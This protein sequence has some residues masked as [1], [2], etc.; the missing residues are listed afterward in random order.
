MVKEKIARYLKDKGIKQDF[1]ASKTNLSPAAVSCLVNGKRNLDVEE[2][3]EICNALDVS[4]DF[5]FN[6]DERITA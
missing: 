4:Y 3:K 6:I 5:F 1:I 2:Y